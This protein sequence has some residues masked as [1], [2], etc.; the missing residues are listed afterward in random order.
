MPSIDIKDLADTLAKF[1]K[2]LGDQKLPQTLVESEIEKDRSVKAAGVTFTVTGG[3]L[4][5]LFNNAK[6]VDED[7]VLV[8]EA[9]ELKDSGIKPP[10]VFKDNSAWLKYWLTASGKASGGKSF[11]SL[12]LNLSTDATLAFGSYRKHNANENVPEAVFADV[13]DPLLP[14][15][16]D[17]VLRLRQGEALTI[18]ASG[19]LEA[20][21]RIDWADTL[22]GGLGA[23]AD[24]IDGGEVISLKI[25]AEASASFGIEFADS[26]I[27]VFSRAATDRIRVAIKKAKSLELSAEAGAG[28]SVELENPDEAGGV[29]T[30]LVD[31]L[32]D[33]SASDVEKWIRNRVSLDD[34]KEGS[35]ERFV[36]E[37]VL[38][39]LGIESDDDAFD[40]LREKLDGLKGEV[41]KRVKKLAKEKLEASFSYAYKRVSTTQSLLEATIADPQLG[42]YHGRLIRANTTALLE[43]GRT[44]AAGVTLERFLFERKN[45]TTRTLKI[46]LS[47]GKISFSGKDVKKLES[48]VREDISGK[49]EIAYL[50]SRTY[51]GKFLD[52]L[53][54]EGALDA[55][56]DGFVMNPRAD[57]FDLTMRLS[58]ATGERTFSEKAIR[59]WVDHAVIWRCIP[60]GHTESEVARLKKLVGGKKKAT[61]GLTLTVGDGPLRSILDKLA[62]RDD[63][64]FARALGMAMPW[65]ANWEPRRFPGMRAEFYGALW[66]LHLEKGTSPR[67]L[68]LSSR[69]L[70]RKHGYNKLA[71]NEEKRGVGSI[72]SMAELNDETRNRWRSFSDG[73]KRLHR[74]IAQGKPH[75]EIKKAWEKMEDLWLQSLHVRALGV[76]LLHLLGDNATDPEVERV[77]KVTFPGPGGKKRVTEV[78]SGS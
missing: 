27:I 8:G 25:G 32:I 44:G 43:A 75:K 3:A 63:D 21:A 65:S 9:K 61:F 55:E 45:T 5:E 62:D 77:L 28:I 70:F 53:S 57:D 38:A 42:N 23:F 26:F 39:R 7:G 35:K 51:E 15:R 31:S 41:E 30:D 47:F 46:G 60:P 12:G 48:V 4:V 67:D 58:M 14:V 76:Y 6:D 66:K 20:G 59:E 22:S 10:I 17:D 37:K 18:H 19:S 54:W 71:L 56:T 64:T 49:Q 73:A 33:A 24:L 50:G 2:K 36:V 52:S 78:V 34:L 69:A 72:G 13:T 16:V 68:A 1:N 40:K 74:A 29:I 11:G